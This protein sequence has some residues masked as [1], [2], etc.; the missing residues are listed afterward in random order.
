MTGTV[1]GTLYPSSSYLDQCHV[2]EVDKSR[3]QDNDID[4]VLIQIGERPAY[5]HRCG[6]EL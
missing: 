5:D 2:D 4:V 6:D 3:E 1:N